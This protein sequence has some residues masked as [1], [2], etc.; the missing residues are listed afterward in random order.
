MLRSAALTLFKIRQGVNWP[1]GARGGLVPLHR[2]AR[3][4][5][6]IRPDA[7]PARSVARPKRANRQG[8]YYLY[9]S[10]KHQVHRQT[11][12]WIT[13][14][15]MLRTWSPSHPSLYVS[16]ACSTRRFAKNLNAINR[17]RKFSRLRGS[18]FG[19]D[20]DSGSLSDMLKSVPFRKSAANTPKPEGTS[21]A[22]PWQSHVAFGPYPV[23]WT[24]RPLRQ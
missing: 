17:I 18:L 10:Q 11:T 5:R 16:P 15:P 6:R 3:N 22:M 21:V 2:D 23:G 1:E 9:A 7:P 8:R 4:A 13:T 24:I 20:G 19:D 12:S 14:D